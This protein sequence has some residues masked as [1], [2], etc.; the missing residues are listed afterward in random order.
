M[1]TVA[2]IGMEICEGVPISAA[3]RHKIEYK[4]IPRKTSC[5]KPCNL[6]ALY[7]VLNYNVPREL[8]YWECIKLV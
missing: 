5:Q 2:L 3:S 7:K 6:S 1:W 8:R 4:Q